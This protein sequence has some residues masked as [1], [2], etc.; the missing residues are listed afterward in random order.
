MPRPEQN[1]A[2][3]PPSAKQVWPSVLLLALFSPVVL[4]VG[5]AAFRP[6]WLTETVA[7]IPASVLWIVGSIVTF[8]ALTWLFA[9]MTF[10]RLGAEGGQ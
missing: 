1:E 4:A 5:S 10:V 3:T 2:V 6:A 8:V 9:R 7:G